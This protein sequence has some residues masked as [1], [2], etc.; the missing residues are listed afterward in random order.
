MPPVDETMRGVFRDATR[1]TEGDSL[2]PG[3]GDDRLGP[4]FGSLPPDVL[5][6][7]LL[8]KLDELSRA[9]FALSAGGCL[10][11]VKD[12][13]LSWKMKAIAVSHRAAGGGHL[14]LL[15]YAHER[16]C[17]WDESTCKKAAAG[18]HLD[19]LR[20]AH[21]HGCPW[22][23][24]TCVY[25]AGYGHLDCLQYAREHGSP[26]NEHTCSAAARRGHLDCLRYAH[27]RNCPWDKY[28]CSWAAEGGN[29]NCLQYAHEHGCPW[30]ECT[31]SEAAAGGHMDCLRYALEHGCPAAVYFETSESDS[32]S[33]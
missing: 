7:V 26:W 9:C 24:N 28:T 16:G 19:C 5:R 12:A 27:E 10:R 29:L 23:E 22:N 4:L 3:D 21:E 18:G 25:A 33:D 20:Y 2:I 14:G 11:A 31:C 15:R 32:E 30:D 13:G 17:P 8:P 1:T 6:E